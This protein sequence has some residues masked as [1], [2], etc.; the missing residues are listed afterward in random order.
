M[1]ESSPT[2]T[3]SG[4]DELPVVGVGTWKIDGETVKRSVRAALDD[5]YRHVDTAG[6]YYNE[7][8]IGDVLADYDR[9]DVF[10]I[11]K[12]LPEHLHDDSVIE[13]CRASLDRL[14]TDYLDLYLV[15]WSNPA[16][17][18]R[19]TLEV[20]AR[21]KQE[22]LVR[23]VGVSN[24]STYQLRS[25]LHVSPVDI[26]VNQIEHHPWFARDDLVEYCRENGVVVEAAAP[27]ARGE[28]FGDETR[29]SRRREIRCVAGLSRSTGPSER[30]SCHCPS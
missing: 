25:A 1:T 16:I 22:G 14:G 4:G 23:N 2:V 24:F 26:T 8:E 27:L 19:E 7:D 30:A 12:M 17:S 11:L 3:L 10:L 5:G 15:H 6:G 21:L 13:S 28:M 20:M 29:A 9:D 18:L